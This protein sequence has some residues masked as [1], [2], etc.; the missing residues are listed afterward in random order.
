[1]K[2]GGRGSYC[3]GKI[4]EQKLGRSLVASLSVNG[5]GSQGKEVRFMTPNDIWV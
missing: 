5:L 3:T 4:S 1:M 2:F